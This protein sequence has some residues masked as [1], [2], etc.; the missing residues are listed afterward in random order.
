MSQALNP[1][2][3]RPIGPL[4]LGYAL[5]AIASMTVVSLYSIIDSIFISHGVGPL[6][7]SGIAVAFPPMNLLMAVCLLVAVGASTVCSIELGRKNQ[8]RANQV[9]GHALV[10]SLALGAVFGL[11]GLLTLEPALRLFGAS[12]ATLP[13]AADFMRVIFMGAPIFCAMLS[14]SHVTRASGH[15]RRSLLMTVL[16]V[17]VNLVLAPLFIFVFQWGIKG[18]ALATICSQAVALT[19]F[20]IHFTRFGV[21]VRLR[22]GIYRIRRDVLLPMLSIGLSP[23]LMNVCA[24]LIVIVYNL[25]LRKY[26][27]DLAIGAYGIISRLMMLFFMI[28]IGLTQGMQPLLGYNFGA[29]RPDRVRQTL[30]YGVAAATA[31]TTAGFLAA[32]LLPSLLASMFT[33]DPELHG[34]CVRGLRLASAMFFLVGSQI[35][36]SSYFQSVGLA[37]TAIFLS[38]TRQLIFLL[39]AL[40]LL[41]AL[42]GLDGIWLSLPTSDGLAFVATALVFFRHRRRSGREGLAEIPD[43]KS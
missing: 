41:S 35:V 38:L 24:C 6:A 26:G 40:F 9:L 21:S 7:I 27:G 22:R 33:S 5:P 1:L 20:L 17:G 29:K 10:L 19:G 30:R 2:E 23:F 18:A 43:A 8:E 34:L 15:P 4:L 14:L 28:I 13:Y 11:L 36:I 25:S 12:D 39:P 42:Y 32:E 31:V 16:S 37:S 3:S